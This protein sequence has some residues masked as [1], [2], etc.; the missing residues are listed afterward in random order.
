MKISIFAGLLVGASA[1]A[2]DEDFSLESKLS[3]NDWA[4]KIL[5]C[6]ADVTGKQQPSLVDEKSCST[7]KDASGQSCLWCDATTTIGSGL[8]VSPD[9]KS[10]AGQYW[11]QFCV[12]AQHRTEQQQQQLSLEEEEE[13]GD[14]LSQLACN[15]DIS[16]Q[17]PSLVDENTCST[18]KDD[19]GQ[20]CLWC[21]ATATIGSGGLC[22]SPDQK[23]L[24]GQYWD[25]LCATGSTPSVP[26]PTPPT[27]PPTPIPPPPVPVPAPD[28]NDNGVPDELKCTM[29]A[30]SNVISDEVTCVAQKDVNGG[31]C[32][33]C[34]VPILGGTCITTEMKSAISFLCSSSS[35]SVDDMKK[36][37]NL[38]GDANNSDGGDDEDG[39]K[40]LDPTCLG[41]SNGLVSDKD[42]CATKTDSNGDACIWCDAGNDVF[43]ICATTKEKE[44][45]STYL[46]CEEAD[47]AE[48]VGVD[49]AAQFAVE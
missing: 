27:S 21:D 38:R 7:T 5:A 17:Q 48:F 26:P 30:S 33:W 32:V 42:G 11:D 34:E 2:V 40:T 25:Q 45:L 35:S 46:N 20:S 36:G 44:Y 49:I 41:D 37:G 3:A 4:S 8:C 18:A 13:G 39:W 1:A 47:D 24:L 22:V 19:S 14:W 16:G 29:D 23:S 6:T 43:G 9:Q 10:M 12:N 31:S 15:V 28:D